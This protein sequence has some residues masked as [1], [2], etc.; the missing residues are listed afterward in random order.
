MQKKRASFLLRIA[1]YYSFC[2]NHRGRSLENHF[3]FWLFC[4]E[5]QVS[6]HHF[7]HF[8]F[9]LKKALK[10]VNNSCIMFHVRVS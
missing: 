2:K 3:I 5:K 1:A 9:S 8:Y 10:F 6:V 7:H 4:T